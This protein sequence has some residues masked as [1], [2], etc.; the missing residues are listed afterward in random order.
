MRPLRQGV[1]SN[2]LTLALALR[3]AARWP[4]LAHLLSSNDSQLR[5]L[6]EP[7]G[8]PVLTTVSAMQPVFARSR[9]AGS[10]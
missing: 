8:E 9:Y 1:E 2:L 3:V 6:D 4:P 7:A 10:P 5:Y